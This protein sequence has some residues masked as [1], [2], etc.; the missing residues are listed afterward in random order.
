[1]RQLQNGNEI[2]LRQRFDVET[3]LDDIEQRRATAFP[4]VPTMWI[5]LANHPGLESRDF[6]SL[7]YCSSGGAPLPVEVQDKFQALTGCKLLEGWGMTETSPAGTSNPLDP[8]MKPRRGS[9]GLPL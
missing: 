3:T 8:A 4:G 7:L 9:C 5:A 6:S 1:L 2:L